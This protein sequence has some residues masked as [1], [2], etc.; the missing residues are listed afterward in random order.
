MTPA[1]ELLNR[2]GIAHQLH[3][4]ASDPGTQGY[5]VQAAQ[6]MGV[7]TQRVFKTLMVQHAD[8][9]GCALVPANATLNLKRTAKQLGWKKASMAK[10]ADAQR[11]TGY[12]VGGISVLG[13]KCEVPKMLDVSAE[14]FQSIFISAGQRGL[15]I[16]IQ[17]QHLIELGLSWASIADF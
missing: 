12:I 4:C 17:P 16:E 7:E 13:Q 15:E 8:R 9:Y 1:V 10:P 2:A 14:R 6:S 11:M 5:A 3:R